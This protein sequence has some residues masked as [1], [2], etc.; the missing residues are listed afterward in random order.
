[1][2]T[3]TN[4]KMTFFDLPRELRDSVYECGAQYILATRF[5]L[6]PS[7]IHLHPH[8]RPRP[9]TPNHTLQQRLSPPHLVPIPQ[10]DRQALLR[11]HY[12]LRD[13][14]RQTLQLDYRVARQ[15]CHCHQEHP[16]Y[17]AGGV[18]PLEAVGG[19]EAPGF[20]PDVGGEGSV[21]GVEQHHWQVGGR[22]GV[23]GSRG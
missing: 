11:P 20:G 9:F 4:C 12:L 7:Q 1:M 2:A 13:Q 15:V 8:R 22:G 3:P 16:L 21:E 18:D 23:E 19:R 5:L 14:R 6:T 10:R 17:L